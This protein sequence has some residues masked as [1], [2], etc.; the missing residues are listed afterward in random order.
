M[1]TLGGQSKVSLVRGM[2]ASVLDISAQ[3]VMCLPIS[4]Q[5]DHSPEWRGAGHCDRSLHIGFLF[6]VEISRER[7]VRTSSMASLGV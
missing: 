2:K 4:E 5:M 6:L 7:V 1:E 3:S